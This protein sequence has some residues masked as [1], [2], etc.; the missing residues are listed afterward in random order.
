MI[1]VEINTLSELVDALRKPATFATTNPLLEYY[2]L[3]KQGLIA[4]LPP[5]EG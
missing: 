1:L 5:L 2:Y 4:N 3:R